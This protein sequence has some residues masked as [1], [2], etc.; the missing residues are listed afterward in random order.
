[1]FRDLWK[2]LVLYFQVELGSFNLSDSLTFTRAIQKLTNIR[3]RKNINCRELEYLYEFLFSSQGCFP[4]HSYKQCIDLIKLF[5]KD[6][7]K[8]CH[9][10]CLEFCGHKQNYSLITILDIS[11]YSLISVAARQGGRCCHLPY[12]P[13]WVESVWAGMQHT[14]NLHSSTPQIANRWDAGGS[15]L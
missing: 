8:W 5:I 10:Y 1:M 3:M 9:V 14:L 15:S 6:F 7:Y 11:E 2:C 13:L 4:R 12:R